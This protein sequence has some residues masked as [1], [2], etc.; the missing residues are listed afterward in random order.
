MICKD[1]PHDHPSAEEDSPNK[2]KKKDPNKVDKKYLHPHGITPPCKNIRKRRFRKTLKKKYV[3]APEIEKEVKQLLR[4]D[5]E[6]VNVKWEIINEDDDSIKGHQKEMKI[7]TEKGRDKKDKT[8]KDYASGS[9]KIHDVA[10]HD[11]FGGE[12]S[13]SDDEETNINVLDIDETSRL[14]AEDSRLSDSNSNFQHTSYDYN[15][16]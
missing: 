7:K 11:I 2:N 1:E 16:M 3:E 12:V 13:S 10:E 15:K 4:V 5:N 9:S 14:S 6:A 8:N